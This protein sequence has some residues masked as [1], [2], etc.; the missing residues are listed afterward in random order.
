ML[1]YSGIS[2][3]RLPIRRHIRMISLQME[4]HS[5]LDE[6]LSQVLSLKLEDKKQLLE[7]DNVQN[8]KINAGHST[9]MVSNDCAAHIVDWSYELIIIQCGTLWCKL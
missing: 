6:G 1:L 9:V 7:S 4:S 8:C 5:S 2:A 3:V